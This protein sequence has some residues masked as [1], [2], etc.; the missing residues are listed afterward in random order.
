MDVKHV[1]L[2]ELDTSKDAE[3][4]YELQ[5]KDPR[6]E[7]PLDIT[8]TVLGADSDA[9]QETLRDLLRRR[10]REANKSRRVKL[11]L[12]PDEQE[13]DATELLVSVTRSW[14]NLEI[15]GKGLDC[16]PANA[17][18]LYSSRRWR[19]IREQVDAA[20]ADRS[21]FLSSAAKA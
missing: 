10:Q 5:L 4:G 18:M 16:T 20:I 21:N 1:D 11:L 7:A 17:R 2:S 13:Q 6:T 3:E 8:I 12:T 15:D 14:K 19:W 9:Y